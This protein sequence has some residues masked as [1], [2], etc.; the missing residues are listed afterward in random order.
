M[1]KTLRSQSFNELKYVESITLEI[2]DKIKQNL[3]NNSI[4]TSEKIFLESNQIVLKN[5][6]EKIYQRK[7][8]L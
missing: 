1:T 3:K 8:L 4:P 6:L 2:L 5:F 7:A